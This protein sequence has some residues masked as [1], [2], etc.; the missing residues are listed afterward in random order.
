SPSDIRS[1]P[2][3]RVWSCTSPI[4]SPSADPAQPSR[5]SAVAA[6]RERRSSSPAEAPRQGLFRRPSL[7]RGH[8]PPR[9][10]PARSAGRSG[11]WGSA[12]GGDPRDL[13][14][15]LLLALPLVRLGSERRVRRDG[16]TL[17]LAAHVLD[18]AE[19][20]GER[21]RPADPAEDRAPRDLLAA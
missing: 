19:C 1:A 10:R 4:G 21:D 12:L 9:L 14:A 5:R 11:A 15:A 7:G 8:A 2:A 6:V 16:Q 18:R 17:L 3:A 20:Q 13:V